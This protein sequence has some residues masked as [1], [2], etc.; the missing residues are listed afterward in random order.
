MVSAV[1]R[2][3]TGAHVPL[4]YDN[5]GAGHRANYVRLLSDI[6]G[7][8]GRISAFRTNMLPLL[9]RPSLIISTFEGA[10]RRNLAVILARLLLGR[11]T[12]VLFLR[13]HLK[14]HRRGIAG[15]LHGAVLRIMGTSR[16]VLPL[17]IVGSEDLK[18]S[19][20]QIRVIADPE[21]W[22]YEFSSPVAIDRQLV[23]EVRARAGGRKVLLIA[24]TISED[25]AVGEL[26]RMFATQPL[27]RERFFPVLA[28]QVLPEAAAD[29]A[30]VAD[31]GW[32]IDGWIDDSMFRSL[33]EAADFAWCAYRQTRDMSSGI[34]GR[35]IQCG[36]IPIVRRNS[37]A[38]R[39]G[40][41]W[42]DA[43][44]IDFSTPLESSDALLSFPSKVAP[45]RHKELREEGERVRKM[46]CDFLY[47][48]AAL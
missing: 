37:V 25:K 27:L 41:Q 26:A 40:R 24:G 30:F 17:S 46:L 16:R 35:C 18:K 5:L 13:A 12:V 43:V 9:T 31:Y 48:G 22:D 20:P 4:V 42:T 28:G 32:H 6:A 11:R 34:L 44:A 45:I 15:L 7:G 33:F 39:L 21:F 8:E 1:P 38:E 29:C 14:D 47:P 2:R 36:T 23:D 3:R 19:C 10:P